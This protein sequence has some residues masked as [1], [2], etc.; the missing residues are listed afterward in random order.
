MIS[1]AVGYSIEGWCVDEKAEALPKYQIMR[2]EDALNVGEVFDLNDN[3]YN[4]Y[5]KEIL[6][7]DGT[8]FFFFFFFSFG[9][10]CPSNLHALLSLLLL[11]GNRQSHAFSLCR[12]SHW[13]SCCVYLQKRR[14]PTLPCAD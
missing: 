5:K 10:F 12:F 7:Q 4:F 14:M 11:V 9:C 13:V 2:D 6:A 1:R 8:F 3:D